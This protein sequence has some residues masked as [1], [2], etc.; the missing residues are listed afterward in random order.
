MGTWVAVT[1][2]RQGDDSIR[3]SG[4]TTTRGFRLRDQAASIRYAVAGA[5]RE[6]S[7]GMV[8]TPQESAPTRRRASNK[9]H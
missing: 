2:H 8:A 4:P 1:H 7:I 3:Q 9:V 6:R 5:W